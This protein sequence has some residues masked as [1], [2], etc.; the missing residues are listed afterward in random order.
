MGDFDVSRNSI[1]NSLHRFSARENSFSVEAAPFKARHAR[2]VWKKSR[3]NL[4]D[5]AEK[6]FKVR[7]ADTA[8]STV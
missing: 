8:A 6:G 3:T 5:H 4:S 7:T 1:F 2:P